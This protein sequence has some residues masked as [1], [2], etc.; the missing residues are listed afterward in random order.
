MSKL[1]E[2]ADKIDVDKTASI[3]KDEDLDELAKR[4]AEYAHSMAQQSTNTEASVDTSTNEKSEKD[5]AAEFIRAYLSP[6]LGMIWCVL[7]LASGSI[8]LFNELKT[9]KI[10]KEAA[11]VTK[12]IDDYRKQRAAPAKRTSGGANEKSAAPNDAKLIKKIKGSNI[13]AGV[14][15]NE[16][17]AL[18][19]LVNEFNKT[20]T[21]TLEKYKSGRKLKI[22]GFGGGGSLWSSLLWIDEY[23]DFF[24]PKFR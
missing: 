23:K 13:L 6:T 5:K 19:E 17:L 12:E 4:M 24:I 1:A 7:W 21:Q 9:I 18:D 22:L 16:N 20:K 11:V 10:E 8:I 14:E 15:L 2:S 3:L